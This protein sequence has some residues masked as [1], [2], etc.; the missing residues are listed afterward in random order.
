M[1]IIT[2][3]CDIM[4]KSQTE[5]NAQQFRERTVINSLYLMMLEKGRDYGQQRDTHEGSQELHILYIA[6]NPS[7]KTH[8]VSPLLCKYCTS[9]T[10]KAI[11]KLRA[12]CGGRYSMQRKKF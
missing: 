4:L 1:L 8:P 7:E 2:V 3:H 12:S 6:T 11:F 10:T 9:C 5:L